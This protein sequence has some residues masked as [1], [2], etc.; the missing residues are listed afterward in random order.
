M[1]SW[2]KGLAKLAASLLIGASSMSIAQTLDKKEFNVVGTWSFLTNWQALEQ[3]LWTKELP[4]ASNG[5]IKGN[6]KSITEVNLKGTELLRL[7]KQGVF[8]VAACLLY[9]SPSPRD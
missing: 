9:T 6:I 8:D 5:A 4:A 2:H 7:L 3:P 1:K